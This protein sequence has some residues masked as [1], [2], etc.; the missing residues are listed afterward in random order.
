[1]GL[2]KTKE[3][4]MNRKYVFTEYPPMPSNMLVELAN[5]CNHHCV[6]CGYENMKR[7]KRSCDKDF[8][9]K[10]IQEAYK[11][12]VREIGFYLIGEPFV[13]DD[14]A[15]FIAYCKGIG[16]TYIYITSNG[17]LATPERLKDAI[18]AGLNSIKF[19]INA[20]SKDTYIKI[21]GK[22]DFSLVKKNVA[23]LRNYIDTYN[24]K[25]NTF[26]SFI[27][28]NYNKSEIDLL[29]EQFNN[30][31]DKIYIN[32]CVN[33]SGYTP[34]LIEDGIV[35]KLN[36]MPVP[37]P[38]PFKNL[39]ITVEGYLDACCGDIDGL[40]V[41]ADLHKMSLKDAWHSDAMVNL[42]R[43]HLKRA[44]GNNLC[45]YCVGNLEQHADPLVV[46]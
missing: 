20:A 16:F 18:D 37:C 29:Y 32:D 43:Q 26:I 1:M 7:K 10:I 21:H 28:C 15:S 9:K 44:I 12:G 6:F 23:W 3:L 24:I 34:R 11:E 35:D 27:K 33:F 45:K 4:R 30:L 42:R 5:I 40:L 25:L 14:L 17:A 39:Y 13:Y 19:S 8:T 36:P 41:V 46:I 2:D 38:E 31:V 22:D